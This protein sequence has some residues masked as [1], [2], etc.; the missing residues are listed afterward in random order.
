MTNRRFMVMDDDPEPIF[1]D[2]KSL[3]EEFCRSAEIP[4][5]FEV[6]PLPK[7]DLTPKCVWFLTDTGSVSRS[8]ESVL[9]DGHHDEQAKKKH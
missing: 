4:S 5:F 9:A 1:F 8:W 3:A 2:D 7:F 6:A